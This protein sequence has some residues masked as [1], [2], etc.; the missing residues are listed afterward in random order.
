LPLSEVDFSNHPILVGVL[1]WTLFIIGG[2]KI[3]QPHTVVF[4][5]GFR[6]VM[7]DPRA[8]ALPAASSYYQVPPLIVP[9]I[10]LQGSATEASL[11]QKK[12][13]ML[14]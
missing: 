2:S 5:F 12:L 14:L 6:K 8:T 3:R 9:S 1:L 7:R 10:F 4:R 13:W 11:R